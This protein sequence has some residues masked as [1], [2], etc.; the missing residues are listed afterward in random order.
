MKYLLPVL[1]V[2]MFSAPAFASQE[3]AQKKG[4]MACHGVDKKIIGPA[5]QDV[6]AKYAGDKEAVAK[7]SD[8]VIK[9]G[10]GAWGQIPMPANAVTPDEAKQLVTW[11]MSLK[12]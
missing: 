8:K 2:A 7:L 10:V 5:Y 3:L 12:K 11:V 1:A 9:G 4:C 6:A